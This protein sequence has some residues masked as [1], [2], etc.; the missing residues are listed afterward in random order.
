M[1]GIWSGDK[2]RT[3]FLK[4]A[5]G[6]LFQLDDEKELFTKEKFSEMVKVVDRERKGGSFSI[7]EDGLVNSKR[8]VGTLVVLHN[9]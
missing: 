9:F 2:F 1:G 5:R 3:P 8:D 6:F 4:K 7:K